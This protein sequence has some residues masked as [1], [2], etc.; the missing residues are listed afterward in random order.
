MLVRRVCK[1]AF[2]KWISKHSSTNLQ[3]H[4]LILSI[5]ENEWHG[6]AVDVSTLFFYAPHLRCECNTSCCRGRNARRSTIRRLFRPW[7]EH[8]RYCKKYLEVI[9]PTVSKSKYQTNKALYLLRMFGLLR[10]FKLEIEG[11]E[12][13]AFERRNTEPN[14]E[15][16][17]VFWFLFDNQRIISLAISWDIKVSTLSVIFSFSFAVLLT[18]RARKAPTTHDERGIDVFIVAITNSNSSRKH[19]IRSLDVTIYSRKNVQRG[20]DWTTCWP[21]PPPLPCHTHTYAHTHA[22]TLTHSLTRTHARTHARTHSI[23]PPD[24]LYFCLS[25][26]FDAEGIDL[27]LRPNINDGTSPGAIVRA[28]MYTDGQSDDYL[29]RD[30]NIEGIV[31]KLLILPLTD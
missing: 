18:D 10:A 2:Y 28:G 26:S 20:L 31:K 3:L 29:D 30:R 13:F 25:H 9:S 11:Q 14:V 12:H 16:F 21:T 8:R 4:F 22:L 15:L 27:H 7:Q 17:G 1:L 24:C 23:F 6:L 19:F 5:C